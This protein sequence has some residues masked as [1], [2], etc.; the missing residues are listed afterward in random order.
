[1]TVDFYLFCNLIEKKNKNQIE[2]NAKTKKKTKN[3]R[4]TSVDF[5]D[6]NTQADK[7]NIYKSMLN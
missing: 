7:V 4:M 5:T 6:H 1:M 3:S 2:C